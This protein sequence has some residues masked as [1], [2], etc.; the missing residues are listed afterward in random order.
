MLR[1]VFAVALAALSGS[2][3][4]MTVVPMTLKDLAQKSD[5]A[6]V[7]KCLRVD[8]Y[9]VTLTPERQQIY[10]NYLMQV[11]DTLSGEE[12]QNIIVTERGGQVGPVLQWTP[13][14]PS[15]A[16]G[17]EA[18]VFLHKT[19]DGW[20]TKG[21]AQ[22]KYAITTDEETG[23]KLVRRDLTGLSFADKDLKK[24][25]DRPKDPP[26]MYLEDFLAEVR[27]YARGKSKPRGR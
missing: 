19:G 15:Y 17:E 12:R 18:I 5:A 1:I 24:F 13:G 26:K 23:R 8:S 16:T 7:V 9:V 25:V 27:K 20:S 3:S 10:T 2:A 6:Y 21:W 4:A 11:S 14:A 22:G